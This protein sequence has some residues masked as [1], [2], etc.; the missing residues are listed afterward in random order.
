MEPSVITA[1]SPLRDPVP[2]G[3]TLRP[4]GTWHGRES[5]VAYD[6]SRH[7][8]FVARLDLDQHTWDNLD[9]DGWAPQMYDHASGRLLWVLDRLAATRVALDSDSATDGSN[10]DGLVR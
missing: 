8:V 10:P 1:G 5:L 9:R 4:I 7:D 3:W 6:S 2:K